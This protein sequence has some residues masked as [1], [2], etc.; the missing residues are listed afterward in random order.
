VR[1]L[2]K[3]RPEVKPVPFLIFYMG[4]VGMAVVVGGT[5]LLCSGLIFLICSGLI[6][7]IPVR[8]RHP[9]T[10]ESFEDSQERIEQYLREMRSNRREI[11][12]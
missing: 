5:A 4:T 1:T 6:F 12:S 9:A 8:G 2:R 11:D 10:L 7:L 3:V